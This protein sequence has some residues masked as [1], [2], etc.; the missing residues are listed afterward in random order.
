MKLMLVKREVISSKKGRIYRNRVKGYD[1][2]VPTHREKGIIH[3]YA[4]G[5]KRRKTTKRDYRK[6]GGR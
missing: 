1:V 4:Y 2:N 6:K 3:C 5:R